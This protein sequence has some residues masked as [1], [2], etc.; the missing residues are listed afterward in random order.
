MAAMTTSGPLRSVGRPVSYVRHVTIS[1]GDLRRHNNIVYHSCTTLTVLCGAHSRSTRPATATTRRRRRRR[2][3]RCTRRD[4]VASPNSR[5]PVRSFFIIIIIT[6]MYF[7]PS[8]GVYRES[9]RPKPAEPY[10][11]IEKHVSSVFVHFFSTQRF[12]NSLSLSLSNARTHS[13][14]VCNIPLRRVFRR[15]IISKCFCCLEKVFSY[16]YVPKWVLYYLLLGF[17]AIRGF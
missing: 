3:S 6:I 14:A 9:Y 7:T 16:K 17:Y 13:K 4:H 2:R 1:R 11:F 15:R 12:F 5:A 10:I 8:L